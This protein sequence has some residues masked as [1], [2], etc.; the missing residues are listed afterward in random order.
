[1]VPAAPK[2]T[3]SGCAVTTRT[4]SISWSGSGMLAVTT[5]TLPTGAPRPA[6]RGGP[7]VRWPSGDPSVARPVV[8]SER[9]AQADPHRRA[10]VEALVGDVAVEAEGEVPV[11]GEGRSLQE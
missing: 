6:G 1:M 11:Q 5:P 7:P 10:A 8:R 2:S 3:S 4:R 9:A